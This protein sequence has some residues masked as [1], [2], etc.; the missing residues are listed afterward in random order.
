MV[1]SLKYSGLDRI[2]IREPEIVSVEEIRTCRIRG[3]EFCC[4]TKFKADAQ[5]TFNE[6]SGLGC[7]LSISGTIAP[8]SILLNLIKD[9]F[10]KLKLQY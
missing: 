10:K 8:L 5:S 3:T 2:T 6:Y 9:V 7:L 4:K 1:C